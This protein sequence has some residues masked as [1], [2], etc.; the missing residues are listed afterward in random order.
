[1]L[2]AVSADVRN[3]SQR[4]LKRLLRQDEA[5]RQPAFTTAAPHTERTSRRDAGDTNPSAVRAGEAIAIP[6]GYRLTGERDSSECGKGSD[7][8]R[9]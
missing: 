9:V 3:V 2:F 7:H 6:N 4:T 5:R 1:M 8:L